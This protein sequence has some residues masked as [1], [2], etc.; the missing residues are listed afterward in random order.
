MTLEE[1]RAALSQA[2]EE[3][4]SLHAEIGDNVPTDEQATKWDETKARHAKAK[5]D[6]EAA[7]ARANERRSFVADLPT[8]RPAAARTESGDAPRHAPNVN[9]RRDP[10]DL[11]ESRGHGMTGREFAKTATDAILRSNE[12][13][14]DDAENQAH[15]ERMVRRFAGG[16]EWALG[17][18]GRS[19]EDYESAFYKLMVGRAEMLTAEERTAAQVGSNPLGGYL[20]PT[21]LDPTIILTNSGSSN[22]MRQISRVVQLTEGNVWNGVTSAGVTASFDAE[23]TEVSDDT[24]TFGNPTVTLNTAKSLVQATIETFRDTN[25]ASDVM[26]LFADARD[27]LEGSKF[28]TGSGTNEP[29]GIFTALDANTNV[30]ITSTTAATIGT[31]DLHSVYRQVPFR[32]RSRSR[33]LMAP[34][35]NLAIKSLGTAVSAS[36]STDLT[37]APADFILGRP[38]TESDDAPTTQTTTALDNELALGDFSNYVIVDKPGSMAVEFIPHLFSTTTNLPDGRRGW[39]AYWSTGGNSV[40]DV[41]FRLLQDK[42]SA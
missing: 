14:I 11:L 7:E 19:H 29:R 16:R 2:A 9:I 35:Y 1:L 23:L 27:R 12:H 24:P 17:I 36:Y 41:A 26:M 38:V 22:A 18:L 39:Y 37:Q 21:H 31:V 15:F 8:S 34:V 13:R 10:Y 20:V 42:T 3:L 4:R 30:E 25:L 32:W 5:S 28:M 40:N 33:W 6:L